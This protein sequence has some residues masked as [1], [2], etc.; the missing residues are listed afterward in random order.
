MSTSPLLSLGM[1]A[2]FANQAALQTIGQNIANANTQGY[3]RQEVVLT[4]PEGQFTGAGYFGK[5][6]NVQTVTRSHNEFLTREA[7][8]AKS[9]AFADTTMQSQLAQLEKLFPTGDDGI[10]QSANDFLNALV[11]VASRPS[12]PSA[13]QVVLGK[14]QALAARFQSAG[15]QLADLQSGVVSDMN[16]DVKQV[17]E[18]AKQ[19]AAA[20][21]QIARSAGTSHTPNDLLDKR[22]QLISQLSQYVQVSTVPNSRDGTTGVFIGGGQVLV[23]GGQAQQLSVT[24]DPYDGGRA[25]LSITD[26][27]GTRALD[28]STL[29]GGSLTAMLRYQNTHLQDARNLLGQMA[30]AI[31]TRVNEQ[32]SLG[33]DLKAQA[34]GPL[35]T[36]ANPTVLPATTNRG[37]AKL[38]ATVTDG[39]LVPALSFMVTPDPT[40]TPD[41]YQICLLYTSPSRPSRCR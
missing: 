41:S 32:Q 9:Q 39:S 15:Q 4:T 10:G 22:D 37:D 3:S 21:D 29:T 6:V 16:A 28:D 2:M 40:G 17:N 19:I 25:Q 5:G 24:P 30:T 18:L 33:I 23:L 20:N 8:A 14:A 27:S 12:D 31:A 38:S 7:A 1:R 26:T 36:I 13:R 34:G 35:F 11:D